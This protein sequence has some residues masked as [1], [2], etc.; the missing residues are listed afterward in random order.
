MTTSEPTTENVIQQVEGRS[1]LIEAA[2]VARD[3]ADAILNKVRRPL[4][5]KS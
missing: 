3:A 5:T 4:R 1:S 2:N